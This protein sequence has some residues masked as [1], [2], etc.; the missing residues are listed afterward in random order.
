[1]ADYRM[2]HVFVDV[3]LMQY[4]ICL[5]A[6]LL[7]VQLKIYVVEHADGL[8]ELHVFRVVFLGKLAHDLGNGLA[9]LDMERLLVIALKQLMRLLDCRNI[10]HVYTSSYSFSLYDKT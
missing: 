5:D 10:A 2:D 9:V 6:V 8:P 1:M 3:Q 7:R 4:L